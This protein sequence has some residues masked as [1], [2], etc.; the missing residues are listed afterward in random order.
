MTTP[1]TP[2]AI[3]PALYR[4]I[5]IDLLAIL[6]PVYQTYPNL[7]PQEKDTMIREIYGLHIQTVKHFCTIK[8]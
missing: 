1:T 4:Q 6:K 7:S 5:N 2:P 3:E 8:P